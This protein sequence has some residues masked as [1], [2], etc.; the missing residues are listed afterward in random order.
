[1][2]AVLRGLLLALPV[3]LVFSLLLS[4]ADPIFAQGF[5]DLFQFLRI[6]NLPENLFRLILY[7]GDRIF[8]GRDLPACAD[9]Q[10]G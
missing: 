3:V 2:I 5:E 1:M 8:P 7:P 4:S 9:K 6:E 10:P